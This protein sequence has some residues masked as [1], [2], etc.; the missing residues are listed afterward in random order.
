MISEALKSD[1]MLMLQKFRPDWGQETIFY[2]FVL[3][4][5]D[6]PST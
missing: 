4:Y 6:T 2:E 5:K 3:F 1:S